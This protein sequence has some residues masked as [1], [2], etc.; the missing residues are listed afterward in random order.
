MLIF[1]TVIFFILVLVIITDLLFYEIK[2]QHIGLILLL[3]ICNL[4]FLMNFDIRSI[5]TVISIFSILFLMCNKNLIGGGDVKLITV[6]M[7]GLSVEE[8][9]RFLIYIS[10]VGGGEVLLFLVF[11]N[12]INKMREIIYQVLKYK[13]ISKILFCINQKLI[14]VEENN[15]LK[16]EIPYGISI[17]VGFMLSRI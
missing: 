2:N 7:I 15:Y 9:F 3:N 1:N 14:I 11:K 13:F 17:C 6:L 16:M 5:I 8:I 4:L 12:R 10:F